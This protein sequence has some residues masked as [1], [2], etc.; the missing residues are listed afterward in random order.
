MSLF[1]EATMALNKALVLK[2]IA[3]V[4]V[5]VVVGLFVLFQFT[6]FQIPERSITKAPTSNDLAVRPPKESGITRNN[7]DVLKE[8]MEGRAQSPQPARVEDEN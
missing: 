2:A 4:I 7:L 3:A 8:R 5:A 1:M 6:S